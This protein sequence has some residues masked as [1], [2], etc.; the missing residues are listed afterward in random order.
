LWRKEI[1]EN[2]KW[3]TRL[4]EKEDMLV[5]RRRKWEAEVQNWGDA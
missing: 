4:E 2:N 1:N 5:E 3:L